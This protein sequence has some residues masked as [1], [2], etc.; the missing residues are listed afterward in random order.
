MIASQFGYL[1]IV[2]LLI[3]AKAYVNAQNSRG[4]TA[5]HIAVGNGH[6]EVVSVL[7]KSGANLKVMDKVNATLVYFIIT[8]FM[9]NGITAIDAAKIFDNFLIDQMLLVYQVASVL[10][11]RNYI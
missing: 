1:A 8:I 6:I 5:L 2:E 3:A 11:N 7:L 4:K 9:Q 10:F